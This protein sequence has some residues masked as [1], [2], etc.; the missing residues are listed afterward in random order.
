MFYTPVVCPFSS[1]WEITGGQLTAS[2]MVSQTLTADAFA[3]TVVAARA[4]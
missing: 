1:A 2:T 3:I 4:R